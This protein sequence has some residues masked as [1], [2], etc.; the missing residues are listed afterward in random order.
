MTEDA[1]EIVE[2]IGSLEDADIDLGRAA[3]AL[4]ALEQDGI[5]MER[6]LHHIKSLADE[7]RDYR[8]RQVKDGAADGVGLQIQALKAVFEDEYGYEGDL[9]SPE[10][11]QNMSLIRVIERTKGLPITLCILCIAVGRELGWQVEGLAIP[12]YFV[13]RAECNGQRAIFD[14]FDHF[15]VLE[16]PD[17]RMLVKQAFGDEAEL[18]AQ[19]FEPASN[20]D[21]LIRLHNMMKHKLIEDEEYAAALRVVLRMLKIDPSEY[22]LLMDAGVLYAKV[23]QNQ[24]AIDSLEGFILKA[25]KGQVYQGETREAEILLAELR[26]RLN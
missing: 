20:R 5:S 8:A 1:Q 2:K 6:Y 26:G 4:A 3:I 21:I 7:V 25:P 18:S 13:C 17:L 16:A 19:F 15:N 14:P 9:Q 23:E 22:R 12:G 11:I 10:D 24:A